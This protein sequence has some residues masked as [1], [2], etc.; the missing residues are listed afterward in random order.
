MLRTSY[1][2]ISL[3]FSIFMAIGCSNSSNDKASNMPNSSN[4]EAVAI[5]LDEKSSDASKLEAINL[6]KENREWKEL[7][8][9]LPPHGDY[10]AT[11]LEVIE[12]IVDIGNPAALPYLEEIKNTEELVSGEFWVELNAAITYLEQKKGYPPENLPK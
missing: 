9:T 6:L 5:I 11:S 12:S 1:I 3:F 10:D 4:D 2:M 7:V 8:K